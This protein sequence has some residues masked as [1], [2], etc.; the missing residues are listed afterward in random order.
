MTK[1]FISHVLLLAAL[2][3]LAAGCDEG[4]IYDSYTAETRDGAAAHFNGTLEGHDLWPEGYTL[5]MAGFTDGNEYAIISKNAR[6]AS[7]GSCDIVLAGIPAETNTVELCVI[8]RLRR[9]VASFA[10]VENSNSGDT[11]RIDNIRIDVSPAAAIQNEIFNTTCINCHGG[12]NF[13]AAG[14]NLT[15]GKSF[16]QLVGVT[17]VKEPDRCRVEAGN[18]SESVLWRIL[19]SEESATWSYDHSVE[20]VDQ[21]KLELIRDWIDAGAKH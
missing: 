13:E 9:K 19:S 7:D 15:A 20:I 6:V 17:S 16:P 18:S 10:K 1:K 8:D 2:A 11:L 3:A 5:A 12:S 21:S 14:L 4:R